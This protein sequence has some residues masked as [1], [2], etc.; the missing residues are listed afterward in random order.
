MTKSKVLAIIG[1]VALIIISI[2]TVINISDNAKRVTQST[3]VMNT[4]VEQKVYGKNADK[5]IS[6]VQAALRAFED[7]LSLYIENSDIARINAAAGTQ[8][9]DVKPATYN[10]LQQAKELSLASDGSFAL[11]I[12][13]LTLAWGIT[14]DNPRIVPDDEIKKLLPLVNDNDLTLKDGKAGL[15][16]K[17]QAIDLGG[18]AKGTACTLVKEIYAKN[19]IKSAL[20]SL[21]GSSIYALGTKPDGSEYVVGFRNPKK[22]VNSSIAAFTIKDEVLATS[23]GYERFFEEKGVRY[24]HIL[25]PKTG[26]PAKSDIVSVGI[27][28]KDGTTAD[29]MSTTLFVQGLDKTLEYMKNGGKVICLDE[30][31]NLY[32]SRALESSFELVEGMETQYKVIFI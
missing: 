28:D 5:A 27:I 23:G 15:A 25:D 20:V 17:E 3:Y 9:V 2:F 13:P 10:L 26:E 30:N 6:E 29:F 12:A 1:A 7:E 19:N 32:V 21:G 4:V 18:I 11:T 16:K 24:H 31:D 14:S 8:L 22:D